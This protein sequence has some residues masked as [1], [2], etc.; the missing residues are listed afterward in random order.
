MRVD[1][2]GVQIAVTQQLLHVP[3]AGAATQQMRRATVTK[4]VYRGLY[5]GLQSVV[6]DDALIS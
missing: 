6:A 4:G 2:G 5:C 1:F 3:E